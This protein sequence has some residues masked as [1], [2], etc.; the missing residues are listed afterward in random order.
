MAIN[1][2]N[3]TLDYQDLSFKLNMPTRKAG[4]FA[5]WF[6]GLIDNYENKVPDVSE[7]ETLWD[8]NDSWSRQR[9]C[10]LG[11]THTYRLKTGGLLRS[12]VAYTGAYRKLG[13]SDY[14]EKMNQMPDMAGRNSSWSIIISTQH[15]HKF[16]SRYTMQNGFEHQHL[17]FHTW[18]DYIREVGGPLYRVYESEGKTGLTLMK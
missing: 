14:D 11:L 8:S 10:A 18:L 3:E 5:L 13:V 1:M 4:T 17:D 12:S 6:T 7:W 15:Q 9:N 16:S 2:E